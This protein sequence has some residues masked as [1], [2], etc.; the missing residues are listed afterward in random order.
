VAERFGQ[1]LMPWQQLVADVGGELVENEQGLL[2]P[3]Y[4]EVVFT[5]P[6]QNGKTSLVLA[7]ECQRAIGWEHLGP[8]RISYSAQTGADARKKLIH[9]QKPILDRAQKALGIK[10]IYEAIGAEGVVWNNGSRLTL[11]NNTAAGGH[12]PT[13]DLGIKDELFADYDGRRDQALIPAMAT[14][15]AG[16]ALACSTMGTEESIPWN[17]LVDRGRMAVDTDSRQGIAYFEWS[18]NPDDDLDDP[19][20]WP[21]FMPA[22]D[23]TI[24]APVVAHARTSLT[25]SEFRRAF[26]NLK[27]KADDRVLP[28]REWDAACSDIAT[29]DPVQ[30]FALDVNPERSAGAIVAAG[31]AVAELVDHRDGIGWTVG[32]AT[33]LDG[34]HG[35]PLWVVDSTGPAASLI[36]ALEAA[37]LRV[38]AA[39]PRDLI[40]ACG[41]FYDGVME[42]SF[43]IRRHPKLDAAAAGAGK[44]TVG[45]AWAWTRK[46]SGDTSP[47]VAATLALWG[48]GRPAEEEPEPAIW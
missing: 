11:L 4:R 33:D 38:H 6:R 16:Q 39:S 15:A 17:A 32:R 40:N 9:D 30:V 7:W 8:Q 19:R 24:T 46:G 14:K 35:H 48:A 1:P 36:P 22:F 34:A 13:I 2:I 21:T 41:Q 28:L 47:L 27:T 45:D 42:R 44:R 29:P 37:G 5:V 10:R 20:T 26:G 3:A 23:Y 25:D 43:A 31:P 12:G 18:A